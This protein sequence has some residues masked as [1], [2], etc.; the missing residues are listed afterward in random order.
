VAKLALVALAILLTIYHSYVIGPRLMAHQEAGEEGPH[1]DALRRQS[2]LLS[3]V[4][5]LAALAILLLVALL[6]NNE[7][8]LHG[9]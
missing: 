4:N 2:I 1:V 9:L 3:M 8:S 6:Q 5:L 7:F